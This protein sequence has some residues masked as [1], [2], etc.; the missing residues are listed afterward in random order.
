MHFGGN[1][2]PTLRILRRAILLWGSLQIS[3][4]WIKIEAINGHI[5]SRELSA[6][7]NARHTIVRPDELHDKFV[8]GWT[9]VAYVAV[10]VLVLETWNRYLTTNQFLPRAPEQVQQSSI[11]VTPVVAESAEFAP[12]TSEILDI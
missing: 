4:N 6:A 5:F 2:S 9:I 7:A 11:Q 1:H 12:S 3:I 10:I 8:F